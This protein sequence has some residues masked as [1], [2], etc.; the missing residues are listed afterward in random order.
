MKIT[1]PGR[2][3][4][5]NEY[6]TANR[7]NPYEGARLKAKTEKDIGWAILA[8]KR[9]KLGAVRVKIT[10]FE[11][12]ERRD[13][14]NVIFAQKF[15]LDSLV[16]TKVIPDDSRKYVKEITH[17]VL[18]DKENPRIEVELEEQMDDESLKM[19][20]DDWDEETEADKAMEEWRRSEE[21]IDEVFEKVVDY[22]SKDDFGLEP[23]DMEAFLKVAEVVVQ[24]K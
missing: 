12:D 22:L 17:E 10:W 7:R 4:G 3:P 13:I 14:D 6:T 23:D 11:R 19:V 18:V 9:E 21:Y 20:A 2:L 8:S 24:W 16:R 15:I 5:L 1:I